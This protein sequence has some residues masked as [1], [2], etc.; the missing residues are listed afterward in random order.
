VHFQPSV[1]E[2]AN[3]DVDLTKTAGA[4]NLLTDGSTDEEIDLKRT[5]GVTH[6]LD[7]GGGV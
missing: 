1:P 5:V 3:N 7:G 4:T 6:F 2:R